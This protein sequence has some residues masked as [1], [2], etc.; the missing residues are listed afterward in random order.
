MLYDLTLAL[1]WY[2]T[3]TFLGVIVLPISM[4]VFRRMPEC[5]ILLSRPLG[6]LVV[7]CIAWIL[8][9]FTPFPF[10]R[11][12]LILIALALLGYS[13]YLLYTRT[14]WTLRRLRAHWRTA[15]NGEI[16]TIIAFL[17]LLFARRAEP[18]LET[19]EK[20][21]DAMMLSACISSTDIPPRDLW[22]AGEPINYHYGG[23]FLHS[24]PAKLTGIPVEY[25]Y[26]LAIPGVAAIAT[27]IAFVLG[28]ALFGRCRWGIVTVICTLFIGNM[29]AA[30][31][32]TFK[33]FSLI[34]QIWGWRWDYLWNTSRIIYDPGTNPLETINEYPF[35][36]MIWGDLHPHF[37]NIPFV[38]FFMALSYSVFKT[39]LRYSPKNVF[40]YHI[41]LLVITVISCGFL[42]PTNIF[43][44]P[45]FSSLFGALIVIAVF[46]RISSGESWKQALVP[47]T[48]L[49]LPILGFLFVQ[50][51]WSNFHSP[52]SQESMIRLSP[53]QTDLFE[54]LLVF[55]APLVATIIFFVLLG[56]NYLYKKSKDVISFIA[57]IL[58][59]LFILL[60]AQTGHLIAALI[61]MIALGLWGI[62]LY[63]S[64]YKEKANEETTRELYAL[65]AC[66]LAWSLI[67]ACEFIYLKDNYGSARMNTLF[68][69]HFPAWILFGVG[70]PYLLYAQIR[71]EDNLRFK[72]S[73]AIVGFVVF[74]VSLIGPAYTLSSLYLMPQTQSTLNAIVQMQQTQPQH[75]EI[76]QWLRQNSE[77]T[78]R[79]LEVPGCAYRSENRV[80][81]YASRPTLLGWVNHE[82]V[83]RGDKFRQQIYGRKEAIMRF[84]TTQNW[85]EAKGFLKQHD[86]RYV[87]FTPPSPECNDTY[88]QLP[89]MKQGIFRKQLQPIITQKNNAMMPYELYRVPDDL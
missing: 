19:T 44:F 71:R 18:D 49:L 81:I 82:S 32:A 54:F 29:A 60:W 42:L 73:S 8:A 87:V 2:L 64:I 89:Q 4:I 15:F 55:G 68:K 27:S 80:S 53:Y 62:I 13:V 63:H 31:S 10:S 74:I 24:I 22:F 59:I 57:C 3:L 28:R 41:P 30:M 37:S 48:V 47:G 40:R 66:A 5:G 45:I 79:I 88:A 46:F 84:Y 35:F 16:L 76:I 56:K 65:A 14:E 43:D 34:K 69:F 70:L 39:I 61:P 7:S 36:S 11:I 12:G 38:L 77:R 52:L 50:P 72:M 58:G 51:F 9:Y 33:G 23:Y 78:D 85:Q 75:Y 86:I 6:W 1:L 25:A 67:S 17:L 26:N 83:W 21:M 20:P